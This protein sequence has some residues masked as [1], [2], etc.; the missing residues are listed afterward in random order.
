MDPTGIGNSALSNSGWGIV[1]T[2]GNSFEP[3]MRFFD[4]DCQRA[5]LG[6]NL[7][8]LSAHLLQV[9]AEP[10]ALGKWMETL[11]KVYQLVIP[12]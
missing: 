4:L 7:L 11:L 1:Q 12:Y 2:P 6:K 5:V 10:P 8:H 3:G 9:G